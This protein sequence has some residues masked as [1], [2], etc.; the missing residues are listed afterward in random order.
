MRT[1]FIALSLSVCAVSS[2]QEIELQ[3]EY[4]AS[5]IGGES[6]KF[7]G[8][9]SF[10]F[11]GFYCTY[12]V[13]GKGRCEIRNNYLYLYFEKSRAKVI[14]QVAKSPEITKAE[15]RDSLAIIDITCVDN[16]GNPV[17][18][19]S[20]QLLRKNKATMGTISDSL[21][22]TS[23]AAKMSDM[24]LIFETSAVGF[25]QQQVKLEHYSSYKIKIFHKNVEL[26]EKELNKG[27]VYIYEIDELSEDLILMRPENSREQ[28][29]K[30]RKKK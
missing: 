6:I 1:L 15:A 5:F 30:Y 23:F 3:G 12:G 24:P 19:A 17:S 25:E 18:F 22:R 28:F 14:T 27:E 21:G 26:E 29:R 9:D 7:V 11:D 2:A 8:K 13:H 10:Y 16:N 20:V 4:G